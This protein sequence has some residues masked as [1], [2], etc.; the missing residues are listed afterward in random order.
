MR[1]SRVKV[2]KVGHVVDGRVDDD[3]QVALLVVLQGRRKGGGEGQRTRCP[4]KR[5][6]EVSGAGSRAEPVRRRGSGH[7]VWRRG[8]LTG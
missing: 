4:V 8:R 6:G 7:G 1:A 2:G 5:D 3:P